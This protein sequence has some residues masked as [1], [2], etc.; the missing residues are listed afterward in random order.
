MGQSGEFTRPSEPDAKSAWGNVLPSRNSWSCGSFLLKRSPKGTRRWKKIKMEGH[1]FFNTFAFSHKCFASE[2]KVFQTNS[3]LE[4]TKFCK[5]PRSHW[6]FFLPLHIFFHHYYPLST[7]RNQVL[8]QSQCYCR[9]LVG[10]TGEPFNSLKS[11]V[12]PA[13]PAQFF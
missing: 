3:K 6:T 4:G 8:V 2:L 13:I 10:S 11:T 5:T 1:F 7:S 9:F 12:S